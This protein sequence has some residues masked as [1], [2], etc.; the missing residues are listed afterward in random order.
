MDRSLPARLVARLC[1]I[2]A[3]ALGLSSAALAQAAPS[4]TPAQVMVLGVFHFA[5]PNADYAK[6]E[7]I[8]V[9]SPARQQ[10]VEAVVA[11]LARFR[12]TKIALERVPAESASI[13]ADYQR[14]LAGSFA[15]T[16][17]EIHQLGFRL[18][19]RLNHPHLYPVDF[20]LGLRIDSV[21]AYAQAHDTAFAGRFQRLITSVVETLDRKQREETIGANLR[22]LNDSTTL[23]LA[24]EP[25]LDMATV[26]ARD[27]YVGARV[28]ADWYERNLMIFANLARIAEPG[29]RILLIIGQGHTPIL[30]DLV[31]RHPAME[32]VDALPY[33]P[34]RW[35]SRE[36]P[37]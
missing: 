26:G 27:G 21:L 37:R 4:G 2:A 16:R 18:G 17:N 8:D 33:L 12:P 1:Q 29:D 15:L 5:N 36:E 7:G 3:L 13:N 24:L 31:E 19:A 23:A 35:P 9:L 22:F 10:E 11:Q 28:V 30:R 25:Y 20:H 34:D 6:F 14:Y 32:L